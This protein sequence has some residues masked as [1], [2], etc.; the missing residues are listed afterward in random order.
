MIR[1]CQGL[2]FSLAEV[3]E[4]L[5][6]PR[7]SAQKRR[8]RGLVDSKVKELDLVLASTRAMKKILLASRY[9]ECVDL[10]QCAAACTP[11]GRT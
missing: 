5:T 7:G 6:P 10:E 2:G 1:F 9:C 8:W 4:L 3:R 11:E